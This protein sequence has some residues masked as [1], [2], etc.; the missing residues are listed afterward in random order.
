VADTSDISS[1]EADAATLPARIGPYRI[2]RLLGEGAMG[3]VFLAAEDNPPREVAL[4]LLRAPAREALARFRREAE[5]LA[6]LEHPGIARLYATGEADLGGLQLPWLALEYVHGDDLLAHARRAGLDLAARLRLVVDACRAVQHAHGRGVIHRDLKPANLWVDEAGRVR[7]LDFGI[8]RLHEDGHTLTAAGQVLGTLPYMAPEQLGGARAA[9]VRA[10]VYALGSV[11]FELLAGRLPHPT[12][13]TCTLFEAMETVRREPPPRL[14]SLVPAA[15]G[16]L[17]TV[18]MKALAVE[19]EAR[20][21]S[22]AA[23][24]DDLER[25]L[26]HRPIAA[27]PPTLRYL[28]GRL[29]R[30]HRALAIAASFAL[31]ALLAAT[32]IALRFAWSEAAARALAEQRAAEAQAVS[33]FLE[34]MLTSAD[35]DQALGREL[36][37]GEV[38]QRAASGLDAGDLPDAVRA[39]LQ[40]TLGRT[41]AKLG[42]TEPALAAFDHAARAAGEGVAGA[43]LRDELALDRIDALVAAS[44]ATE[45]LAAIEALES[46]R[47][48]LP[49]R[50]RIGVGLARGHALTTV[51]RNDEAETLLRALAEE[52]RTRFGD[53]DAQ[54]LTA[55][56][57]LASVLQQGG[58]FAEAA[59]ISAEV[60]ARREAVYG[61][62]HPETLYS[63]NHLAAVHQQMGE[64]ARAEPLMRRVVE[65]RTRVLGARHPSTLTSQRNLAVLMIASGRQAEGVAIMQPVVEAW[66][67]QRGPAA[68]VTL[69]AQ[70]ILAYA[71]SDLGRLDEAEALLRG[72]VAVQ[73]AG[74]PPAEPTLLSPRNDLAML[75]M[76]RGRPAEALVEF[77]GLMQWAEA[78]LGDDDVYLAIFRGNRGDCLLR[79][80]RVAEARTT[81][82]SSRAVLAT[83]LGAEHAR[84]RKV[85][86]L[87]ARAQ[88]RP[89]AVAAARAV[90][91]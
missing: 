19:P 77:D 46:A 9:D 41:Y 67:A 66:R 53:D 62:D 83:K 7:V 56:H 28:A 22:A 84:T 79:L 89:G 44:R 33:G 5:V 16:D 54:T 27:R 72:I 1:A 23:F 90:G 14:A 85:D 57:N 15:R 64:V 78:M 39:R 13:S 52:S 18:V 8:A 25:V 59:A 75:L 48:A 74:A 11:A 55:R 42:E 38:L 88:G 3:R 10:D 73:V 32:A 34:Q 26:D 29:V 43:A 70:Q 63:L 21:D 60:L 86:A 47:P 36:R 31:L 58:E 40:R 45:A 2:L 76:D 51:G 12:L 4:K 80:G 69:S 20:Y 82:A 35:P 17:D 87:L 6:Q 49:P 65:A 81:L 71:Y 24:A 37:V 61:P 50:L 30:R 68:P 91:G